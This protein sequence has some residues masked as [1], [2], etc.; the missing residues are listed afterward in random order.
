MVS[1]EHAGRTLTDALVAYDVR[2]S[3]E[4]AGTTVT[5]S[6]VVSEGASEV[7]LCHERGEDGSAHQYVVDGGSGR[8]QDVPVDADVHDDEVTVRFPADVV[9]VAVEW[10]VWVAVLTV[11][12]EDVAHH[13]VPVG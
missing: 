8:R 3:G 10:P 12:G 4:L 5:W 13:A 1:I 6:M 2:W 11:D 7:R 9:G